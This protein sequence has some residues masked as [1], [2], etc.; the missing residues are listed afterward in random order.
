EQEIAEVAGVES[1]QALLILG[2]ELG[3]AASGEGFGFAGV[4]LL[5]RPAA[6]LPAIDEAGQLTRG[7]ALFVEGRSLDQ[8][9][10]H[11]QLVVGVEDGE[12]GSETDEFGMTSKHARGD[13]VERAE[14]LHAFKCSA[15]QFA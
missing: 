2:V 1:L 7:P 11:A 4:Y 13:R 5:G 14:P 12:I 10:D 6:V 15:R 8:L 9:L 3:P